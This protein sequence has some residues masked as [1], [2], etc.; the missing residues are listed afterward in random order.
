MHCYLIVFFSIYLF[1]YKFTTSFIDLSFTATQA[2]NGAAEQFGWKYRPWA[3]LVGY[4]EENLRFKSQT[5]CSLKPKRF[6]HT[7]KNY[8]CNLS[9]RYHSI[10]CCYPAVTWTAVVI[11]ASAGIFSAAMMNDI[12]NQFSIWQHFCLLS[13]SRDHDNHIHGALWQALL[14]LQSAVTNGSAVL[15]H[16]LTKNMTLCSKWM[17]MPGRKSLQMI[18]FFIG[19]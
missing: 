4:N 13:F 7:I 11:S 14:W 5:S 12:T 16:F 18:A 9:Q 6:F 1:C 10:I 8:P 3:T 17:L 2:K 15:K 19:V